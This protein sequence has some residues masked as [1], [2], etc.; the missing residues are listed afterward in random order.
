ML[1]KLFI[2][3]FILLFLS[4]VFWLYAHLSPEYMDK[5]ASPTS[6]DHLKLWSNLST[7]VFLITTVILLVILIMLK[8]VD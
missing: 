1:L 6:F 8:K 5:M 2:S 4:F 3:S 7:G